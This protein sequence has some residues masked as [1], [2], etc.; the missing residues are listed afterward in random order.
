MQTDNHIQKRNSIKKAIVSVLVSF[1]LFTLLYHIVLYHDIAAEKERYGYIVK[2]QAEHIITT[3]DCV[4]SRTNTLTTMVKDHNGETSWFDNVAEDI[5]TTVKEETGVSLKNVAIAPDGVVSNVYPFD[6][7]EQLIGFDFLD[8]SH[9]GNLEAKE[10]YKNGKTIITNPFKL[11]QGGI[12]MG[13]RAPVVFQNKDGSS[14]WGLVTVTID[15]E[16]LIKVLGLDNLRGMGVDYSLSYIDPDGGTQF[17]YGGGD[18]GDNAV[19]TRFDVRNL[20]WEIA[21]EP[22]KGWISVWKAVVS[23]VIIMLLSCIVGVLTYMIIHIRD[24][25]TLLLHISATDVLT[26]C[27]NRRAY[28]DRVREF[29]SQSMNDDFVYVSAD[30][31]G[32]KQINDTLGH[33]AG[34]ELISGATVCLQKGFGQYGSLYRIGGDEFAALIRANEESLNGIMD[35]VNSIVDSW[36]GHSVDRM[37]I[38][39]G[40]ASHRD[41]P[42]MTIEELGKIADNKMYEA[43]KAYYQ[44]HDKR[45]SV[46]IG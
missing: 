19:K 35:N 1:A 10:A 4:M 24:V 17:M 15:F 38:S 27:H 37:S 30:I 45:R 13:G 3:I 21:V 46:K 31:N 44:K 36:K 7:N 26:G 16:N 20:T 22:S 9:Q 41:F 8:T 25:N 5:Y 23:V 43:K 34:D 28:E 32:L 14:F 42:D 11:I 39:I 12:G 40:Y 2:N 18:I 6:G 29:S 33:A